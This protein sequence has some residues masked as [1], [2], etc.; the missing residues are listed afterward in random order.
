M[1]AKEHAKRSRHGRLLQRKERC[2]IP[3]GITAIGKFAKTVL[4]SGLSAKP[5]MTSWTI[6]SPPT[7]TM[8]SYLR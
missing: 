7:Q 2:N 5:L 6:P 1:L 8:T 4:A 3:A